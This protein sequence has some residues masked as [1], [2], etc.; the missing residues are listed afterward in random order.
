MI[1]FFLLYYIFLYFYSVNFLSFSIIEVESIE[2]FKILKILFEVFNINNDYF[3]RIIPLFFSFLS[4]ILFFKISEIYLQKYKYIATFIFLFIPGFIVS[5]ILINKAIFLIFFTL[6]FIYIFKKY[7]FFAYLLLIAY[8]FIDY[9]FIAL[10]FSLIFYAIYKKDTKFLI[11]ILILMAVNANY[12]SYTIG[13]KPKGF[14]I[15]LLATYILIFSPFVFFYFMYTIYKGFFIK[16]DILFFIGSFTFL[17]SIFLSFR[18]RIRIDDFAPFVLPYTIYMFRVFINSYKVR[19]PKFRM[20]YKILFIFLFSTMFIFDVL[21]F[22][23]IPNKGLDRSIYFVKPLVKILK[24]YNI[25]KINCN[26]YHLCKVLNFYGINKGK[27]YYIKYSKSNLKVSI[28]HK[29][30]KILDIDVSNLNTLKK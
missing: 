23:G 26:N 2:K 30:K 5:S 7:R 16:K 6:F 9:S 17:I 12:F 11:F 29:N 18:Q 22:L 1:V 8:V 15:E 20:P 13:G 19:L 28:F 27:E 3:L 24:K 21:I 25:N 10:Y 4:T 14:L